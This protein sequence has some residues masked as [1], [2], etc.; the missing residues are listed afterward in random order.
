M[1]MRVW[2]KAGRACAGQATVEAAVSLPLMFLLV[3]ML[4]QPAILLYDRMIMENAAWEGARLLATGG[5]GDKKACVAFVKRRLGAVPQMDW[6]HVH[7]SKCTWNIQCTG[8][9]AAEEASVA[10]RHEV[11]ALPLINV[12]GA[13]LGVLNERGC[14]EME[15]TAATTTHAPWATSSLDGANPADIVGAW[16]DGN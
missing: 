16:T 10:I 11:R 5:A 9:A 15:V 1:G 2:R 12:G 13:V 4:T 14:Y 6:F 8:D 7:G 3:L